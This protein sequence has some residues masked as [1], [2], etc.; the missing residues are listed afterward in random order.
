[1][2]WATRC[3]GSKTGVEPIIALGMT[4]E[5]VFSTLASEMSSYRDLP[6]IWY[7]IQTK[8]RDEP[9]PKAGVLRTREF[10]MKDSYSF[11]IDDAGLDKSFEDHR[12]AYLRIFRRMG[13]DPVAI[14]ASSGLMGGSGS[15]EFAVR[16]EAGED[17]VVSVSEW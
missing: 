8:F 13:L 7:Q 9:R 12:A 4:H 5:E 1:M 17:L 10:T 11:D 14:D 6:Q 15:T 3:F 16:S 2:Q